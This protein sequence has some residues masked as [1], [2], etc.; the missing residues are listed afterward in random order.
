MFPMHPDH[1]LASYYQGHRD[2]IVVATAHRLVRAS[3]AVR[4]PRRPVPS[5][6]RDL[7]RDRRREPS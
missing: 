2:Y 1:V 5:F 7:G 3:V 6:G 4:L